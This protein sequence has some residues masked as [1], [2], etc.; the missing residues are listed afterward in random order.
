M[1]AYFPCFPCALR[2]CYSED[3]L[4]R[5]LIAAGEEGRYSY[6]LEYLRGITYRYFDGK[7]Q[8]HQNYPPTEGSKEATKGWEIRAM[9]RVHLDG[10]YGSA[11]RDTVKVQALADSL[12]N[13]VD[14]VRNDSPA[15]LVILTMTDFPNKPFLKALKTINEKYRLAVQHLH[16]YRL[17]ATA[18]D[19]LNECAC[20]ITRF[21]SSN[22]NDA[23]DIS[24][25]DLLQGIRWDRLARLK[26]I[27]VG[28]LRE[29]SSPILPGPANPLAGWTY[30]T[31]TSTCHLEK[32]VFTLRFGAGYDFVT[33]EMR[34]TETR[35]AKGLARILC[36]LFGRPRTADITLF[37]LCNTSPPV[38]QRLVEQIITAFNTE[39]EVIRENER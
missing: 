12:A 34:E 15:T 19:M 3:T 35:L 37:V 13:V 7:V 16:V 22:E 14:D 27:N 32:V 4:T 8:S 28:C 21:T 26:E 24:F 33:N 29:I 38:D 11:S 23:I 39:R 20:T 6:R 17:D 18:I 36:N 30:R 9:L 10:C 25:E 1:L 31:N 2:V 5:I